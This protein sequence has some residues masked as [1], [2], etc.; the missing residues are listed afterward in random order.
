MADNP[1]TSVTRLCPTFHLFCAVAVCA[2]VAAGT[3][4][5]F[6]FNAPWIDLIG[7]SPLMFIPN[8]LAASFAACALIAVRPALNM[9]LIAAVCLS[10][11]FLGLGHMGRW[12]W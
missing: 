8:A 9:T 3:L 11:L 2:G 4:L 1:S 7:A 5:P 12:I 6:T 10:T